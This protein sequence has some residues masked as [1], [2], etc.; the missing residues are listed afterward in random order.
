M[1]K[2]NYLYSSGQT[3]HNNFSIKHEKSYQSLMQD[4]EGK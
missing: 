4:N 3:G 1:K 2:E